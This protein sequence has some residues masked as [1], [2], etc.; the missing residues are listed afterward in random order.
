M[1]SQNDP[2]WY[3]LPSFEIMTHFMFSAS[4][5]PASSGCAG[6]TDEMTDRLC[7]VFRY[8][9]KHPRPA[10]SAEFC[11]S[12]YAVVPE[13]E[14]LLANALEAESEILPLEDACGRISAEFVMPY[15]PGIPLIAPGEVITEER[16]AAVRDAIG[17]VTSRGEFDGTLYVVM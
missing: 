6:D 16:I 12:P 17:V 3:W 11:A 2:F 8:L 1:S 4:L 9:E 10:R 15:P 7:G 14:M 5:T 13:S